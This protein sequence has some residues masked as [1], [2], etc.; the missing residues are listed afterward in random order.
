MDTKVQMKNTH[1]KKAFT[2]VEV[3]I[4]IALLGIMFTFLYS[5]INSV[6]K[7][8]NR[9]L[10][11]SSM[12]EKE[13]EIFRLFSLDCAQIVGSVSISYG[14]EYDVIQFKTKHSIYEIIEPS[15]VYLVSKKD[16]ALLRVESLEP[17]SLDVKEKVE[18]IFLYADILTTDT[19]SFKGSFK[20]GFVTILFRSKNLRAMVL[21]IP[22]IS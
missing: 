19:I 18:E 1:I 3:I 2:L 15:V 6:K 22:T 17:F 10:E 7:Q 20:D 13:K 21:K 5:S 12:I 4:S 16:N 8:N 9:Y 11:K 14:Q